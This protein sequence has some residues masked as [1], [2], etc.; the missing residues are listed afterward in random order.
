VTTLLRCTVESSNTTDKSQ[1]AIA[2]MRLLDTLRTAR[3]DYGWDL[4]TLC[5]ETCEQSI[6]RVAAAN[7]AILEPT[8]VAATQMMPTPALETHA[9]APGTIVQMA[10]TDQQ[11][12]VEEM[13]LPFSLNIPWDHLWDDVAEP[14]RLL[15][16]Y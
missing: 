9:V 7:K 8:S 13:Q 14:W 1:S 3:R 4:A 5:I 2:L 11:P 16:Q 12:A 10:N 15:D 6:E